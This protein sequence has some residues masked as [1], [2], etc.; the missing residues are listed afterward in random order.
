MRPF[1][2]AGVHHAAFATA[3]MD[4]TIAYWR[5]LLGLPMVLGIEDVDQRQ[6]AFRIARHLMV[7]FFEWKA[8]EPVKPKRHGE[9][10]TGP[11]I[12]DHLAIHLTSREELI[13]LQNQLVCAGFPASDLIDHGFLLSFYTHDPNGIPLEFTWVVP[14]LEPSVTP[15][16]MTS[17]PE[18]VSFPS[19]TPDPTRWPECNDD[20]EEVPL[21]IEGREKRYFRFE[22]DSD[23]SRG[24]SDHHQKNQ[25]KPCSSKPPVSR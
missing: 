10:V 12:F 6:Y 20:P 17:R 25:E 5:D 18:G 8:V 13:R 15:V 1:R 23:P 2:F 22:Q 4:R 16:F 21:I 11:F 19:V 3:D 7:F 9:P 24:R 14:G